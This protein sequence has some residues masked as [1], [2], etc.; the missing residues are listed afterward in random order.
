M[1]TTLY[2]WDCACKENYVHPKTVTVCR[3]CGARAETQPDSRITEVLKMLLGGVR[4]RG[5]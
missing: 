3:R 1:E 5:G 4:A 2:F